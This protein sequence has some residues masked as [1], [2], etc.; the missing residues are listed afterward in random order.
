MYLMLLDSIIAMLQSMNIS[1]YVEFADIINRNIFFH[2]LYIIIDLQARQ[3]AQLLISS[4]K[5]LHVSTLSN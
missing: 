2:S 3:K 1:C 5:I 4:S